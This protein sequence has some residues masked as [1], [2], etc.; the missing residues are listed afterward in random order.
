VLRSFTVR[1]R[2]HH[3]YVRIP[4]SPEFTGELTLTAAD[5][6]GGSGWRPR[7]LAPLIR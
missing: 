4:Y 6:E 2:G 3:A 5:M 1:V 7:D